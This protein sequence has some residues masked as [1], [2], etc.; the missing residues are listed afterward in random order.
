MIKPGEAKLPKLF[1]QVQWGR[2]QIKNR[3]KYGA[4]CVSNYNTRDGFI[5]PRE[6]A[7]TK[8][9]ADRLRHHHQPGRLP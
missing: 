7:R 6:L 8:V 2:F 1:E 3:V 4:C 9:I 5:T